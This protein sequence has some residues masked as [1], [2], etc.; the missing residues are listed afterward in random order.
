[1][2]SSSYFLSWSGFTPIYNSIKVFKN[3]LKKKINK[4]KQKKEV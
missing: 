2:N 1:M 4:T 3:K